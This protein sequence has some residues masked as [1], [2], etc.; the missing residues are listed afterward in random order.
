MSHRLVCPICNGFGYYHK[1]IN[2]TCSSCY[3]QG[4]KPPWNLLCADCNGTGKVA[5][6]CQITCPHCNGNRTISY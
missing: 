1:Y 2:E 3:G 5:R 6:I 4:R